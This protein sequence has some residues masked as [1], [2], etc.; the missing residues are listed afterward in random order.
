[1]FILVSL[2]VS[3]ALGFVDGLTGLYDESTGL[4]VFSGAY[5]I[6]I[7]LPLLAVGARRLHDTG[8]SGWWLLMWVIPIIG[9][10]VLI[11]FWATEG[12]AGPNDYGPDPMEERPKPNFA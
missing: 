6:A 8:R 1:M 11:V 2:I 5:A 3:F 7:L 9:A 10:I 4:G 12:D